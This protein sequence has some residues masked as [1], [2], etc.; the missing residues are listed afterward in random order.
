LQPRGGF[1]GHVR[2]RDGWVDVSRG[3][4]RREAA[5]GAA[6]AFRSRTDSR[7][8]HARQVRVVPAWAAEAVDAGG[9]A[10]DRPP[11]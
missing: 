2:Y 8:E 5:H 4:T 7:G 9:R 11:A 1:I 3:G 10:R 6:E